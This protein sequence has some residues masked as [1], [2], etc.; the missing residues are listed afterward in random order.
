MKLFN[1][2]SVYISFLWPI[3]LPNPCSGFYLRPCNTLCSNLNRKTRHIFLLTSSLK[4]WAFVFLWTWFLCINFF[5]NILWH[6]VAWK[7]SEKIL[8]LQVLDYNVPDFMSSKLKEFI[9][10][11]DWVNPKFKAL[12]IGAGK[13]TLKLLMLYCKNWNWAELRLIRL[14]YN[15]IAVRVISVLLKEHTCF[16]GLQCK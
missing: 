16:C 4:R 7:Y 11:K 13:T 9:A 12:D 2:F 3:S 15:T 8:F 5:Y 14:S 10:E 6:N 1:W